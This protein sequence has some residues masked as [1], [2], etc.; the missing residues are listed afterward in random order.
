VTDVEVKRDDDGF[1]VK[2]WREQ[3]AEGVAK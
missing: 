2:A 3:H 1:D